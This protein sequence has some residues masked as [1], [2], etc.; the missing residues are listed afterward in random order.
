MNHGIDVHGAKGVID[1]E[2]VRGF[3]VSFAWVKASEGKTF[4]D[5]RFTH[6]RRAAKAAGIRIGAYHYARPDNNTP[7]EE[8]EHFLRVAKPVA[9]ELL[10]ALDFEE[11]KARGLAPSTLVRWADDWLEIVEAAIGARPVFYSFPS[12]ISSEMGGGGLALGESHLWLA[13]F[14]P[15]DGKVHSVSPVGVFKRIA[16]HQFTSKGRVP[17]VRGSCDRNT[18]RDSS[19]DAITYQGPASKVKFELWDDERKL[20]ESQSVVAGGAEEAD[21]YRRFVAFRSA[22][23]LRQLRGEK[24]LGTISIKRRSI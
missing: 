1:W 10:P 5:E 21:R 13:S 15:N 4:D 12:Y 7:R 24:A 11:P 9:G 20:A 22:L 19:L 14:G 3:G 18:L 8:A 23:A 6:N 16:A 17:G 2:R